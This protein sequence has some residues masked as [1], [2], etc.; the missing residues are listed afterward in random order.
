MPEKVLFFQ[1]LPELRHDFKY[2]SSG[3]PVIS[4]GGADTFFNPDIDLRHE[5]FDTLH[6][7]FDLLS[8]HWSFGVAPSVAFG[9]HVVEKRY[10]PFS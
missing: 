9:E 7:F 5:V 3:E 2:T 6:A 1:T 4:D 8:G 10:L